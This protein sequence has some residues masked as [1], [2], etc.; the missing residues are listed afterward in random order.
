MLDL[1]HGDVIVVGDE[2]TTVVR[3]FDRGLWFRDPSTGTLDFV[4]RAHVRLAN[5]AEAQAFRQ[6]ERI[7]GEMVARSAALLRERQ[8][9]WALSVDLDDLDMADEFFCVAGHVFGDFRTG[10]DELFG[11]EHDHEDVMSSGFHDTFRSVGDR[12]VWVSN[13]HLQDAWEKVIAEELQEV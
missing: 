12:E 4:H 8:P 10:M 6:V 9:G 11:D 3:L 2:V 7:A 5:P 13:G 1:K